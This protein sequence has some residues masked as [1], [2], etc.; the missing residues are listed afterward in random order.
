MVGRISIYCLSNIN[1]YTCSIFYT[2]TLVYFTLYQ[3]RVE[4]VVIAVRV[5]LGV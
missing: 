2:L 4:F 3:A 1:L 5:G